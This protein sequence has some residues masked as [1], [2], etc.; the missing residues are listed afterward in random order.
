MGPWND[1]DSWTFGRKQVFLTASASSLEVSREKEETQISVPLLCLL[2][3]TECLCS[4]Q[5]R[6]GHSKPPG[7]G[8]RGGAFGSDDVIRV[9]GSLVGSAPFPPR[10]A[11]VRRQLCTRGRIPP[12]PNHAGTQSPTLS[13]VSCCTDQMDSDTFH[14]K[15][16]VF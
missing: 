6:C 8:I 3:P 9:A 4:P 1:T 15:A 11:T 10:E 16:L 14:V 2:Q 13:R 7:D 12:G 5:F